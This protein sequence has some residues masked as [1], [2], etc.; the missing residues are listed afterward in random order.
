ML[1]HV[2]LTAA[3]TLPFVSTFG[4][5]AQTMIT[6]RSDLKAVY[7]S[8]YTGPMRTL[9]NR[10]NKYPESGRGELGL[11]VDRFS[12]KD[13]DASVTDVSL[14]G[15]FGIWENIVAG[16][17]V[18]F[19]STDV[20][21]N[22]ESGLGDLSL[23]LDLLAFQ[24]IFR[25]PFV[26]PYVTVQLP[27]GDEDKGLGAGETVY[28]TG[29]S[30]GTK[31]YDAITYLV[32]ISYLVNGFQD[33]AGDGEDAYAISGSLVW[34]ISDRFAVLGE[35]RIYEELSYMDSQPYEALGG[36]AYRFG[37]KSSFAVYVGQADDGSDLSA[38]LFSFKYTL[39][40]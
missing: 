17:N 35:G 22:D 20:F 9:L 13:L 14:S 4:E 5:P 18:P 36:L 24:D 29:I 28:E 32:G 27:T 2:L 26:I 31:V 10:E 39:G 11:G 16:A 21:G 12:L 37:L 1:K 25:Y 30:V 40:F 3:I 23:D 33:A 19:T 6:G 15:R 8:S 38:D 34:D 7:E